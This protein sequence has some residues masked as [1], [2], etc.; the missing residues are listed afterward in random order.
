[1]GLKSNV[2]TRIQPFVQRLKNS[3]IGLRLAKGV[4]WS[5]AGT[6]IAQGLM[7]CASILVARFLGKESYGELG[8]IRST[9]AMFGVFA[10]FAMGLTATKHVAEYRESDPA[11]AGRIISL[12]AT[13][14]LVT[15]GIMALG[16]VIFAPWL[17]E[18]TLNAPHLTGL[19]RI[20]AIILFITSLNGAQTG[21]LAGFE[22]F[23]TIAKVN[24][25]IGMLS[26]PILIT[27]TYIK[28]LEGAV[29][30]MVINLGIG[31]TFNHLALRRE[32]KHHEVPASFHFTHDDWRVFW[33]FS[34]PSMLGGI[35]VGPVRWACNAFLV[36]QP[37]GYA[38]MGIFNGALIFQ[39]LLLVVNGMLNAPLLSLLSNVGSKKS[40]KLETAN[41]LSS[42]LLGLVPAMP[43]L[44]LPEIVQVMLGPEYQGQTFK[45]TFAVVVFYSCILTFRSGLLRVLISKNLL[46]W[47]F[48]NNVLW[49]A[50]LLPSAYFFSEWGAI[51]LSSAFA[52]A[53]VVISIVF[54]P[55]YMNKAGVPKK[56]LISK[57]TVTIWA[58]ITGLT[59]ASFWDIPIVYRI[60]AL[61]FVLGLI[62]LA[63]K[64]VWYQNTAEPSHE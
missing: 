7:F 50:V 11:R 56:L 22:A 38:Q 57:E 51:G 49:A 4:F 3:P 35:L 46:W 39:N 54:V 31:W 10:G 19:L 53:Y 64:R 58:I 1:M 24:L 40:N 52:L 44:C 61:P 45:T 42:W 41:I 20:G 21:A 12:A 60:V 36:N 55:I 18:H 33:T 30:A 63:F 32:M 34:L 23:K 28:G 59:V 13:F 47:G 48:A 2:E 9:V 8:I 26:F 15:G 62:G 29:W 25:F 5:V 17:A 6:F 16:M 27:G 37:E 43:L 14:T